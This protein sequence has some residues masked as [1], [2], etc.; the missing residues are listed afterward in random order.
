MPRSFAHLLAFC[1]L[2]L[3][4]ACGAAED[5][6]TSGRALVSCGANIPV[7]ATFA[8]CVLDGTNYTSGSFAQGG[9]RRA[10]VRTTGAANLK[11]SLFFQSESSPGTDTEVG[12]SEVGCS[13]RYSMDNG[14]T[15]IF[16]EA[17]AD[18]VWSR[19]QQV[20][21][22]GDHLVEVFSDAQADYLL[23]VSVLPPQ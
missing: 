9:T 12:Y 3:C 2:C 20:S 13:A 17:G 11:V 15:D 8:G 4:A 10:I 16:A 21:T 1:S 22:A 14:G 18:R 23:E 7:C 5:D 19:T 6:F